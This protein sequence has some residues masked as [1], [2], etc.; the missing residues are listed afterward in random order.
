MSHNLL[1]FLGSGISFPSNL[2]NS[3][4]ITEKILYEKWHQ[5]TDQNFYEGEHPNE[6]FKNIDITHKIQTFLVILKEYATPYMMERR[7]NPI[8]YED[9]FYICQQIKDNEDMEID[10][11]LLDTFIKKLHHMLIGKNIYSS[12]TPLQPII[13]INY[14]AERS[15]A[16]IQNVVWSCLPINTKPIGLSLLYDICKHTKHIDIVTL[17]HDLLVEKYFNSNNIEYCDG[18]GKEEGNVRYFQP[19]LYNKNNHINLYKIHGSINWFR[20]RSTINGSTIDRYGMATINDHWHLKDENGLF[21]TNLDGFPL[22]LTGSYNKM[23]DYNFGI[24]RILHSKFDL[25]LER[26]KTIIMSGYGWN[27]R[28]IN[29]RLFE[30]LGVENNR[31]I[32]L[33]ENPEDLIKHSKSALWHRYHDL[34]KK[35]KLFS[36]GK[37]FSD[38]EYND[39]KIIL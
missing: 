20:F 1:V 3:D 15:I 25:A 12:K 4:E 21:L 37:W 38:V 17:N 6:Y 18:F 23:L 39:I 7:Q 26:N 31:L 34:V 33:H 9:L 5:H 36:V 28:G 2:P 8:N 32:L 35:G 19:G 14:L 13:N 10:N 24:Y 22:F 27:D 29:G 11:P 30:W 16:L